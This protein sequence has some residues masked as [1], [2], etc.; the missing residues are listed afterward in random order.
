MSLWP[1]LIWMSSMSCFLSAELRCGKQENKMKSISNASY[2]TLWLKG[3]STFSNHGTKE[4]WSNLEITNSTS[5]HT[6]AISK[7]FLVLLQW[8]QFPPCYPQ[9]SFC[10]PRLR[11]Q[12]C[13][14]LFVQTPLP[15]GKKNRNPLQLAQQKAGTIWTSLVVQWLRL[16]IPNAGGLG[17]I[18]GQGTRSYICN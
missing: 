7:G 2:G 6:S 18:P 5:V 17:L 11:K 10:C 15:L 1:T 8:S 3:Q 4:W 14:I 12:L 16:C 13:T 9:V